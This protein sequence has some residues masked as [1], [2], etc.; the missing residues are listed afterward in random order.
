MINVLVTGAGGG[1]GQGIIKSL[2]RITDLDINI[3]AADMSQ[4]AAGLYGG[5]KSYLVPAASSVDYFDEIGKICSKEN[6]DYYFPGT[7]VELLTCAKN[8]F[9]LQSDLNVKIILS[10]QSVIEIADDKMKTV[11]FLKDNGLSYPESWLPQEV[12]LE[13]LHYP[14]IIKPRV[15][16]RSIGVH[17]A[18]NP[19]H[20]KSIISSLKD[21]IIQEFIDGDEFT[22]TL[23]IVK[24]KVS[25]VLC[26]KRDLRSGDTYRAFPEKS[27]MIESYVREIAINL[28]IEGSCNF[29][30]RVDKQGLPKLFEINSRFSG[31]TPFCT[32]L[33]FNP[34][35]FC[36][37]ADLDIDYSP[38]I[39]YDKVILRHWTEVVID[40]KQ[41]EKLAIN[42]VGSLSA[43]CVSVMR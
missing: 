9:C 5:N 29:Q 40:K 2:N 26:L 30:L 32:Y 28:G 12:S 38:I 18:Q 33:G 3:I 11:Q 6:I 31:T 34:V 14:V 23:A 15:G 27:H 7:D 17:L 1:V 13:N 22:C 19:V 35:E 43:S 16:C 20:A 25:E 39:D 8:S 24:G 21:P 42:G 36:L 10:P 37:K 4:L 41:L